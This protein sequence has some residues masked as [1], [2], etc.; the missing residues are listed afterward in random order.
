M[1]KVPRFRLKSILR[2][3]RVDWLWIRTKNSGTLFFS[4]IQRFLSSHKI[5]FKFFSLVFL[6]IHF[7]DTFSTTSIIDIF[8]SRNKHSSKNKSPTN[9]G[10]VVYRGSW[11]FLQKKGSLPM[12][13]VHHKTRDD[14]SCGRVKRRAKVKEV[15]II[16]RFQRAP[17]AALAKRWK[18]AIVNI[19]VWD[20]GGIGSRRT[21]I[22]GAS[23]VTEWF[24]YYNL[25][26]RPTS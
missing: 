21:I 15:S 11:S 10:S 1:K 23:T 3:V 13:P 22:E 18:F 6:S 4:R 7:F 14:V 12:A 16:V 19:L 17:R 24:H 20:K 25:A 9:C 8:F 26:K 2:C 5:L